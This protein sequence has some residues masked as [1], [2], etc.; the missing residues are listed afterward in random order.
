[1]TITLGT[2]GRLTINN[3]EE[4]RDYLISI[5]SPY[6]NDDFSNLNY[7]IDIPTTTRFEYDYESNN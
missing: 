6:A 4:F 1:M 7:P 5:D 2:L 3:A